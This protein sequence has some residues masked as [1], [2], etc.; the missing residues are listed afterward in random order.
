MDTLDFME[1]NSPDRKKVQN[2][3]YRCINCFSFQDVP[4]TC[5]ECGCNT[6]EISNDEYFNDKN[7]GDE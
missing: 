5:A 4:G 3:G 6:E 2:L 7:E 1:M